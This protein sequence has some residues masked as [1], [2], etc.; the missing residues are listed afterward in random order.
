MDEL[1]IDK[2]VLIKNRE[3]TTIRFT[4][5]PAHSRVDRKNLVLRHSIPHFPLISGDFF[6]LDIKIEENIRVYKYFISS[7]RDRTHNQS[8]LHLHLCTC[9]TTLILK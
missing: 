9:A 1:S 4:L 3:L 2:F 6:C 8:R 7:S 5:Y